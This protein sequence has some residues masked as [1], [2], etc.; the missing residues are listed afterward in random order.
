M[1]SRVLG[2]RA[3]PATIGG[4]ALLLALPG[5][6]LRAG[7]YGSSSQDPPNIL[8]EAAYT[9]PSTWDQWKTHGQRPTCSPAMSFPGTGRCLLRH[10]MRPARAG[11]PQAGGL[12]DGHLLDIRDPGRAG[13]ASQGLC[14]WPA[15]GALCPCPCVA[16]P[17]C[18]VLG[19][20][21]LTRMPALWDQTPPSRPLL[22]LTTSHT[23]FNM[24]VWGHFSP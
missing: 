10:S 19:S 23:G 11:I 22:T 13:L 6:G 24:S 21:P 2:G 15:D 16:F 9:H 5:Q 18:A 8:S 14:P 17:P 7:T 1:R 4:T 3:G 12:G 20:L